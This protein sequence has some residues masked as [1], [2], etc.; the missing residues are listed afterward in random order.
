MPVTFGASRV[1]KLGFAKSGGIV[2]DDL[3]SLLSEK[4][5]VALFLTFFLH[6]LQVTETTLLTSLSTSSLKRQVNS[7]YHVYSSLFKR[8]Y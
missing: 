7:F 4:K 2:C 1:K 6:F 5:M 3:G 8:P